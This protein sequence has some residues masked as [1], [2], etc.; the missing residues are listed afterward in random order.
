MLCCKKISTRCPLPAPGYTYNM[1]WGCAHLGTPPISRCRDLL[2][3]SSFFGH[4]HNSH[5]Y[6]AA[7][8]VILNYHDK[9]LIKAKRAW[10]SY[11]VARSCCGDPCPFFV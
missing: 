6:N 2:S 10:G 11:A 9:R 5:Q 7:G 1:I 8:I 4:T 3:T